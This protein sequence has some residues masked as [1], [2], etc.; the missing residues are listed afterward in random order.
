[1][2]RGMLVFYRDCGLDANKEYKFVKSVPRFF[3][4]EK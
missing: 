2:D 1:M 4:K 3:W